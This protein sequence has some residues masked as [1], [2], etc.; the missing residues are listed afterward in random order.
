MG[1]KSQQRTEPGIWGL[2]K[3]Q[4]GVVARRQLLELGLSSSSI[5]HRV[6][7]GRLH[8]VRQGVYAVGRPQLTQH[9]HWMAAILCCGTDAVLSH[10]DAGALWAFR[11]IRSGHIHISLPAGFSR[12]RPG[13][14]IHRR[15]ALSPGDITRH[16]GIPVT[17]PTAT[18][19]DLAARL[20][21]AQLEAAVNEADKLDL[22]DPETLRTA[23]DGATPRPGL[24]RLRDVL[25]RRTFIL[26]DSELERRFLPI[27]RRAGLPAPLTGHNLNGFKTDF[28][29]PEL[30]LVVETDGLRYHRTP[31]QQARDR[32]RDQAHTAAGMTAVRFTHAQITYEPD[33]VSRTL[34]AVAN[35]S[36]KPA[37]RRAPDGPPSCGRSCRA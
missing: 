11:P 18:L 19:I 26:T 8:R 10:D 13:I 36:S 1:S 22:V 32:R 5:N 27:A 31:A 30:D 29:W 12:R 17:T 14:R 2:L 4:H 15:A 28:Y 3:R 37:P 20:D 23:L 16:Q 33:Q 24:G 21:R 6:A 7:N 35:R 9:G 25:D 34:A